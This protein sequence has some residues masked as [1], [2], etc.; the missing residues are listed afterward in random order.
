M[1][2]SATSR[3]IFRHR[4]IALLPVIVLLLTALPGCEEFNARRKIQ[5][6]GK[7]YNEGR[8]SKAAELYEE[9]LEVAPHLDIAHYNAGL[10]YSKLFK[11]GDESPENLMWAE[12]S[13]EH[14]SAYLE[15]NPADGAIVGMMT[16]IWM[17]AGQYKKALAYWGGELAK[18]P[19]DS[20]VLEILAS[21]NRQAGDWET[22][23]EWHHKQA[24]AVH[25]IN[26]KVDVYLL[27]AK[28]VWHRLSKRDKILA[29]ERIKI[30]D[31]GVAAMAKALELEPGDDRSMELH[32]YT[33]SIFEFRALAH[34][35]SWARAADRASTQ[36]HR[37]EWRILNEA[38]QKQRKAEEEKAA[39]ENPEPPKTGY[40]DSSHSATTMDG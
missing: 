15:N 39:K 8:F 22:A 1:S 33:A 28:V 9:A 32:G 40:L 34:P 35:A 36:Y 3:R 10:A 7:L 4:A 23:I 5:K 20:E 2:G 24:E 18:D 29:W 14:F 12:K 21:I 37:N 38:V 19:T 6:A 27:I 30:A 11:P 31:I 25:E 17:D 26:A 13:T 16:R